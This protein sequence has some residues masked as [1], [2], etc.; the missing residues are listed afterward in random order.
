MMSNFDN[1][2][3][4]MDDNTDED[5]GSNMD[6]T[7]TMEYS[8]DIREITKHRKSREYKSNL[9]RFKGRLKSQ[10]ERV[11]RKRFDSDD[12]S[13]NETT[14]EWLERLQRNRRQRP[15][16]MQQGNSV[17]DDED[18]EK[19]IQE[20]AY[21]RHV[22]FQSSGGYIEHD[23]NL[24]QMERPYISESESE[25]CQKLISR[26]GDEESHQGS[27]TLRM[28]KKQEIDQTEGSTREEAIQIVEKKH[29]PLPR[30]HG[31]KKTTS[32]TLNHLAPG[33]S[34]S[35]QQNGDVMPASGAVEESED[36]DEILSHIQ[37][38]YMG[39][40]DQVLAV[41]SR[42]NDDVALLDAETE[43]TNENENENFRGEDKIP[44]DVKMFGKMKSGKRRF[45]KRAHRRAFP[46][47]TSSSSEND[48]DSKDSL[49][50]MMKE[51]KVLKKE[52]DESSSSTD[53]AS[54]LLRRQTVRLMK[55]ICKRSRENSETGGTHGNEDTSNGVTFLP[56]RKRARRSTS[57]DIEVEET[58]KAHI[59]KFEK[60]T[61]YIRRYFQKRHR[62]KH[63]CKCKDKKEKTDSVFDSKTNALASA[64]SDPV[65]LE[66]TETDL[67]TFAIQQVDARDVTL[68][69]H[70]TN[71]STVTVAYGI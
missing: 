29:S 65:N 59:K 66:N 30:D 24:I 40:P 15:A 10:L 67:S 58:V 31:R 61:T 32:T 6:L 49:E 68:N 20:D 51:L 56:S 55:R 53:P 36:T 34:A 28:Y 39:T 52:H 25:P 70:F 8:V 11:R 69:L 54:S 17:N 33:S 45:A 37:Q 57:P 43:P 5:P 44:S 27:K 4:T 63:F 50:V 42:D 22:N 35:Q 12:S 18:E 38:L 2:K 14:L 9:Y 62:I 13:G 1:L 64:A 7:Q 26:R 48:N 3:D 47:A 21:Q 60:G 19:G 23:N 16:I 41:R 46:Q 71:S